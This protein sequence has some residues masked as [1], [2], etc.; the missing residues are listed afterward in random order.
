MVVWNLSA[1][2]NPWIALLA[3]L[4]ARLARRL[5]PLLLSVLFA[6]CRRTVASRFRGRHPPRLPRLL[7]LHGQP[8]TPD[9]SHRRLLAA[10][11]AATARRRRAPALLPRRYPDATLRTQGPAPAST[12][13]PLRDRPI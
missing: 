2:W 6:C 7:L 11:G 1:D 8:R 12:T 3:H 9:R 10:P 13:N 4:H 5:T